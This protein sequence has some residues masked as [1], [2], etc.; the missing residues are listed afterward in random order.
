MTAG[1]IIAY[2]SANVEYFDFCPQFLL[3]GHTA[4]GSKMFYDVGSSSMDYSNRMT[5]LYGIC[6]PAKYRSDFRQGDG[7]TLT[8]TSVPTGTKRRRKNRGQER[9]QG[10]PAKWTPKRYR[11]T[12]IYQG[13]VCPVRNT[14]GDFQAALRPHFP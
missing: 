10:E 6:P 14:A 8:A 3:F 11:N 2:P 4:Q 1:F 5:V 12:T 9:H 13:I 7:G